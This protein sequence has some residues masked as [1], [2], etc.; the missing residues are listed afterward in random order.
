H[1]AL[2]AH[3]HGSAIARNIETTEE[4]RQALEIDGHHQHALEAIVQKKLGRDHRCRLETAWKDVGHAPRRAVALDSST[5]P[6]RA[7]SHIG[8]FGFLAVEKED[9][10]R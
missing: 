8:G 2:L 4:I 9:I 6:G 10:A 7:Q 1:E 3:N 5:I